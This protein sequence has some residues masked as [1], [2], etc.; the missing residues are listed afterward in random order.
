MAEVSLEE[1]EKTPRKSEIASS[2]L[3]GSLAP[4]D[5]VGENCSVMAAI[6]TD[7]PASSGYAGRKELQKPQ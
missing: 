2:P 1:A 6:V 7:H 4:V 5:S 3:S